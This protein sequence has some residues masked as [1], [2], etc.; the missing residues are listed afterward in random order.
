MQ[1]SMEALSSTGHCRGENSR[2]PPGQR[3][4]AFCHYYGHWW[5]VTGTTADLTLASESSAGCSYWCQSGKGAVPTRDHLNKEIQWKSKS[6]KQ[7]TDVV[8]NIS[9]IKQ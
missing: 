8:K 2:L 7:A 3:Q 6:L 5:L 9:E 4:P 1:V